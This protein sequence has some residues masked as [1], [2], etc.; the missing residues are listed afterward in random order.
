MKTLQQLADEG[1]LFTSFE[2][3]TVKQQL[4]EEVLRSSIEARVGRQLMR[5]VKMGAGTTLDFIRAD[6]DTMEF[7]LTAEG[8]EIPIDAEAYTKVQVTPLK[9]AN[10][11]VI[12][13]EL[14][15]DANWDIM[16]MNLQQAGR[17]YGAKE[18]AIIVAAM[19]NSTYGFE[20][21]VTPS[22]H[23]WSTSGSELSVSDIANA[24]YLIESQDY[25]PNAMLTNPKQIYELRQID[26]FVEADKVG[27]RVTF[28][29][30]FV[31]KIFGM[32]VV[33]SSS[34]TADKVY[35]LDTNYAGVLVIRR[36]LTMKTFELPNRDVIAAALTS[37]FASKMTHPDAGSQITVS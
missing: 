11:V 22:A 23:A 18:D 2:S 16:R 35:V 37:R 10:Q 5:V 28:E 25:A 21:S 36:P 32:E 1:E 15:E 14:Q 29:K 31:G 30:G 19:A 8:A 13:S 12:S 17:E 9:Y 20:A 3:E 34:C 6:K 4:F 7:R 27:N 24:M 26:T 33:I